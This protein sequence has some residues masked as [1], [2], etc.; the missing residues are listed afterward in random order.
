MSIQDLV[1]RSVLYLGFEEGTGTKVFDSSP[2]A[3]NGT[4]L[5]ANGVLPQWVPGK[6]G[7]GTAIEIDGVGAYVEVDSPSFHANTKGTI[8][9]WFKPDQAAPE[10]LRMIHYVEDDDNRLV[11][12]QYADTLRFVMKVGDISV[13]DI[14]SNTIAWD[15]ETY[16]HVI[17]TQD[18]TKSRMYINAVVQTDTDSGEWFSDF[19]T[20]T[21]VLHIG[22]IRDFYFDG[23]FDD[24]II[25]P[26]ALTQA[27]ARSLYESR[28]PFTATPNLRRGLVLDLDLQEGAGMKAFDRSWYK[29]NGT[30]PAAPETPTWVPGGGLEFDGINNYLDIPDSASLRFGDGDFAISLWMKYDDTENIDHAGIIIKGIDGQLAT[31]NYAQYAFRM[32]YNVP[33]ALWF[34]ICDGINGAQIFDNF[35]TGDNEP[36]HIVVCRS[37]NQI[38][39]AV[40]GKIRKTADCSAVGSTD[41]NNDLAIGSQISNGGWAKLDGTVYKVRIFRRAPTLTEIRALYA[42]GR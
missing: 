7:F 34:K 3:N 8:A 14:E 36:H 28:S 18:G 22:R 19:A 29:N 21:S 16:Y 33:R 42:E 13:I 20:A 25:L 30:L 31:C 6:D 39:I 40:D 35:G 9:F 41:N 38:F 5:K 1:K 17:I 23:I 27:E 32:A 4:L 2:K 26:F 15:T 24:F 12:Q 11:F 37:G 10:L